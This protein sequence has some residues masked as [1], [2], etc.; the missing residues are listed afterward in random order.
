M[1]GQIRRNL[2]LTVILVL[3]SVIA[4]A[5]PPGWAIQDFDGYLHFAAF[6]V[7]TLLA[8]TAYPR[9][10]LSHIAVGV[11]ILGG[12]TELLQFMPGINRTP[13]WSDFAFNIIGIGAALA[14][15]ILVRRLRTTRDDRSNS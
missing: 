9:V 10:A 6:V 11:A 8:V 5:S 13:S 7:I 4:F 2:A 1:P 12:A 3:G 14:A 15:V